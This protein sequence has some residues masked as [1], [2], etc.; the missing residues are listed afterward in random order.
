MTKKTVVLLVIAG[1][2]SGCSM[3][4]EYLR[5]EAPVAQVWP[6]S[7]RLEEKDLAGEE[8][9][10]AA[11]TGWRVFFTDPYLQRLIETALS[12][13]RDL[14]VSA[15]N[16]ERAR[17]MYQIQR[18]DLLPS[19]A[20][21]GQSSNQETPAGLANS[22]RDTISRTQTVSVGVASY[23]LDFF[24]RIQSLKDQALEEYLATEEAFRSAQISLVAEVASAYVTLVADKELLAISS[25]T[26]DS[27]RASY[28][29]IRRRYEVGVSSELDLRQAQTSV[30]TARVN[31]ARYS[32]QVEQDTNALTLLVGTPVTSDMLPAHSLKELPSWGEIPVGLPSEVLLQRPDI[33]QAE[34]Q[35]R[36]AN[37]NIGAA[38]ANFFPRISLTASYG[39]GSPELSDL[40][41]GGT[42]MWSFIPSISLPIFE[43]G[44]NIANLQVSEADKKIAVA[45]YE[46][47]IQTAFREVSDALVLRW[48]LV[49]QYNAQLSLTEAT[50]EAYRLSRER[51]N[52]GVDSYL[53]VLDS[54]RAMYSSQLDLV[55]VRANRELNQIQLYK[56]LG[57][58][59]K[60]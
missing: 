5:P 35:L 9:L 12:N 37:A 29:M 30:D 57:G 6:A 18:A 10:S 28:E 2:L 25:E 14:R 58:G 27:Q 15:L 51:Y 39:T 49:D 48:S 40:F 20:A 34:H 32:G 19:I 33:L 55:S 45:N 59:W 54:Q 1:I 46:K 60:E 7:A 56:A 38:R 21:S 43:G 53:T 17:G 41:D 3:A 8:K 36:A 22:G 31:I 42:G 26:L 44:R 47:T 11:D 24:G 52:R 16:I 4:P 13:N 50:S 23:E